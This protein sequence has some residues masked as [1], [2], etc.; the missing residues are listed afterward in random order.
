MAD[1][2]GLYMQYMDENGIKY[3]DVKENVVRVTYGGD[4]LASIPVYV[5]FDK[6]GDPMVSFRCWEIAN[7]KEKPEKGVRACNDLN[8]EYRWVKFYIDKDCDVICQADAYVDEESC[9]EICRR[10]VSRIVSIA[11][12]AYPVLMKALWGED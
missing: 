12:D 5:F 11:D 8:A 2:K 3:R 10:M 1:Y 6:D 9:G 4:H 7:L